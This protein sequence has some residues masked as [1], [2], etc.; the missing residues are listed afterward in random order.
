VT[1]LPHPRRV[2]YA[3]PDMPLDGTWTVVAESHLRGLVVVQR[4]RIKWL[5]RE[6]ARTHAF[7]HRAVG[8]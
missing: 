5:E 8:E 4:E 3:G 1:R 7:F 6:L 2:P